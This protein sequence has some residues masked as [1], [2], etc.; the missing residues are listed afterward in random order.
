MTTT[1]RPMRAEDL[2]AVLAIAAASPEAP[3]WREAD[4][5]AYLEPE[6]HPPRLRM[7]MVAEAGMRVA[8]FASAT[9]LLDGVENRCEVDTM[10]VDP[11]VRQQGVGAALLEAVMAWAADR[12]ARRLGL[13]VRA[14]NAAA[15]MLYRRRGFAEEGWRRGYFADPEE[16]ALVLGRPVT[17][18]SPRGSI[19]TEKE[20]EGGDSQC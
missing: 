9:L 7:A 20:V 19:S 14:S 3:R 5:G 15:L 11:G 18:V 16:D 6:P 1:I 2:G 8:G 10:A 17:A 12:G 13:E 4:Y